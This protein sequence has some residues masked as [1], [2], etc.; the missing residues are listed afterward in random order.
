MPSTTEFAFDRRTNVAVVGRD[1]PPLTAATMLPE[2]YSLG[3]SDA[4]LASELR[5]V[6]TAMLV[7]KRNR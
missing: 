3:A 7:D 4:M 6:L 2:R 5:S 1:S